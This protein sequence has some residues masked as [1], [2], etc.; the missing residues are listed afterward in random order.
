MAYNRNGIGDFSGQFGANPGATITVDRNLTLGNVGTRNLRGWTEYNLNDNEQNILEN[1]L[2]DEF[3]LAQANL[4][5]NIAAGR[6]NNFRYYGPGTGTAPLPITLAY[7]SGAPA[8]QANTASRY[9]SSLFANST[10]V[11]ALALNNPNVC[12]G[13]ASYAANLHTDCTST[14]R[15]RSSITCRRRSSTTPSAPST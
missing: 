13:T 5:A 1:G 4:R 7:F 15:R 8:A 2:L 12:C 10:F 9:S 6:G 11:N 3:K 14:M